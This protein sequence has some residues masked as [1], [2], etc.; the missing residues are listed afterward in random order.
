MKTLGK[1]T[2]IPFEKIKHTKMGVKKLQIWQILV[3]NQILDE[4]SSKI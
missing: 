1:I 2:K 3:N 4:N